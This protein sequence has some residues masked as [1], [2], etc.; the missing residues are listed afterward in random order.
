M[1][2]Q[3]VQAK[4]EVLKQT[5]FLLVELLEQ[6]DPAVLKTRRIPNKWSIH[7]HACHLASMD[8]LFIA[9][10]QL[11]RQEVQP[12][13]KS[14]L[15]PPEG[16]P[17]SLMDMDLKDTLQQFFTRRKELTDL[18]STFL[19]ADWEKHAQH[20]KYFDYTPGIMLRHLMLHDHYHMY[21]IEQL[22]LTKDDYL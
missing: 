16:S 13:I 1:A 7:E 2:M 21:R 14:H 10:F 5:P 19:P 3:L 20:D 9:R 6:I 8:A 11:F 4:L 22:W 18:V 17:R 15:P 12:V